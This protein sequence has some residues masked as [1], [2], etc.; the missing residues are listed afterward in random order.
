MID[1]GAY[2]AGGT[3]FDPV[4]WP[5]ND[6]GMLMGCALAIAFKPTAGDTRPEDFTVMSINP[7]CVRQ[8]QTAFEIPAN[9]P[10]CPEGG[11][12]CA[13]FWQG[14]N[15]NDEMYMTGFRC[16]VEGGAVTSD[17]PVPVPPTKDSPKTGATQPVYWANQGS[18]L[19]FTPNFETKPMYNEAWGWTSGAQTGAFGAAGAT[20]VALAEPSDDAATSA[21]R[22]SQSVTPPEETPEQPVQDP[23]EP[24][25]TPE[26]P[27]Q[28][29]VEPEE[30]PEV[31]AD[32][33]APAGVTTSNN[34]PQPQNTWG[35]KNNAGDQTRTTRSHRWGRPTQWGPAGA[36]ATPAE[37]PEWNNYAAVDPSQTIAA[38]AAA[39]S[40]TD[41]EVP[42]VSCPGRKR[43]HVRRSRRRSAP[44]H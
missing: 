22:P 32:L 30:E 40:Q 31:P 34:A 43:S 25:E 7:T 4:G 5:G 11:C 6:E 35:G 29:P 15:S 20:P 9:L 16:D 26:Q 33:P 3:S 39:A 14:K 21:V 1:S 37:T 10:A 27:V 12:T 18:N 24:E 41:E 8:R 19:D 17:Y 38:E 13:W 28:D 42:G 36:A 23:V 44:H 2:H